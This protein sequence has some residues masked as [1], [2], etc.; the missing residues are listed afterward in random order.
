MLKYSAR[1]T[2][3][4]LIESIPEEYLP[5]CVLLVNNILNGCMI[6][7]SQETMSTIEGDQV[8]G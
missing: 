1:N 3:P 6:V 7:G 2:M 8:E 5:E 4:F